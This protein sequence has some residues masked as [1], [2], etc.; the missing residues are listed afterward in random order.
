[1]FSP[2]LINIILMQKFNNLDEIDNQSPR[3]LYG[4]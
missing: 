4:K 2:T 1:M 3:D